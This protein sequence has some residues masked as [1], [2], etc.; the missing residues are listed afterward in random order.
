MPCCAVAAAIVGQLLLGLRA[1]RRALFGGDDGAAARND[2]VEWRLDSPR[3]PVIEAAP[4]RAQTRRFSVR[5]FAVV[6]IVEL[7]ILFG[8]VSGVAK[9]F[10]HGGPASHV[11]RNPS[12]SVQE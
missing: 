5:G 12:V 7:L 6:A 8:A 2:A 10:G 1:V 3:T 9:H 4:R 11:H